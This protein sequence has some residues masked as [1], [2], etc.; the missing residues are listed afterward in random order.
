MPLAWP[1]HFDFIL[2]WSDSRRPT[3]DIESR[4]RGPE[5][6]DDSA[7]RREA[8][9]QGER[10]SPVDFPAVPS[11]VLG[12]VTVGEVRSLHVETN[13]SYEAVKAEGSDQWYKL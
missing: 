4:C 1:V 12:S 3:Q 8:E 13:N 7:G 11:I 6:F 2:Y 9:K 5:L 10:V